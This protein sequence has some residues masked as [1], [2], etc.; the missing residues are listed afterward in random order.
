MGYV[1]QEYNTVYSKSSLDYDRQ[2]VIS[3]E[4][5]P[6][7]ITPKPL[8]VNSLEFPVTSSNGLTLGTVQAPVAKASETDVLTFSATGKLPQQSPFHLE[9]KGSFQTTLPPVSLVIQPRVY[10]DSCLPGYMTVTQPTYGS[11]HN[12]S[13]STP[14]FDGEIITVSVP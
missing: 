6:L 2:T 11:S 1:S 4:N 14:Y 13:I 10:R 8:R 3:Y 9:N 12:G 7:N 5:T